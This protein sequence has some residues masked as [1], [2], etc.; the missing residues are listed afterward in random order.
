MICVITLQ[1]Q[2][3][4]MKHCYCFKLMLVVDS[5]VK[6]L[7]LKDKS[8]NLVP[9]FNTIRKC[10]VSENTAFF[11]SL[12]A[13]APLCFLYIPKQMYSKSCKRCYN[14]NQFTYGI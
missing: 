8:L 7:L 14:H 12:K 5:W 11:L 3:L 10:S 6:D 4:C 13:T 1:Y 9:P 2:Q